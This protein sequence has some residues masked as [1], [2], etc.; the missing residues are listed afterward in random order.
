MTDRTHTVASTLGPSELRLID[1]NAN[2]AREGIRTAEDYLRF[3]VGNGRWAAK[4]KAARH[5]V[6][7]LIS[8]HFS[9]EQLTASRD[10][11]G[12]PLRPGPEEEERAA[13][14]SQTVALRGL[15]RAQEALRVLEEYTRPVSATTAVQ[16]AQCRF[17]L[18]EAEQWLIHG[19]AA[20]QAIAAATVYVVL[21]KSLCRN[22]LLK[23]AEG[24]IRGGA[25]LL[26]FREKEITC[27]DCLLT[28][29]RDLHTL[30]RQ[31]GAVLI[32]NDRVDIALAAAAAGVHLG[33]S[34]MPPAAARTI[35]GERL[36]IGRSTH[37]VEQA[38]RAVTVEQADYIGVG[39]VYDT[40]T[41][42]GRVLG[43]VELARKVCALGL[44][45]PI[46][47]IGGITLERLEE[48]K[49]AGVKQVAVSSAILAASD[50]TD[51]TRR[52]IETMAG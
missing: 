6:S 37:S 46:F 43:G 20:A 1:A 30:C 19:S 4:L 2:R 14:S 8:G 48:L 27:D 35:A 28:E 50:P 29:A 45:V 51:A 22:G 33:Q 9:I 47:A 21:T 10:V 16:F 39:S 40:S 36:I 38:E 5:S 12:D 15:K 24:V 18:Y 32:C 34:D 17:G 49:G 25:T 44:G 23:T 3:R 13:E 52:F 26:Q 7:Q 31:L 41:K 11:P 42:Q